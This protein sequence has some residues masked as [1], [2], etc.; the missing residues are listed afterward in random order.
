MSREIIYEENYSFTH[1]EAELPKVEPQKLTKIPDC[2][3]KCLTLQ[4]VM[5]QLL[6]RILTFVGVLLLTISTCWAQDECVPEHKGHAQTEASVSSSERHHHHEAM[7]TDATH[8]SR[9]C[10]SRPQRLIPSHGPK[11][12]RTITPCAGAVR[13][14]FDNHSIPLYDSRC[15]LE[16]APFCV[17]ALRYYYVVALRHIIC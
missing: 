3:T 8:L 15:R 7:L 4:A 5:I 17:S 13:H 9:V 10:S 1:K 11:P 6:T 16:T 12:Q 14:Q 2:Q